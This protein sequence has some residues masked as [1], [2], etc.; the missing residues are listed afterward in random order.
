[1]IAPALYSLSLSVPYTGRLIQWKYQR[2]Y[3]KVCADITVLEVGRRGGP[4]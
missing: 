1:M 3:D 4:V 2:E